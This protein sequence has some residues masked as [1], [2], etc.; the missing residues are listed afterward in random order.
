MVL[1]LIVPKTDCSK[2]CLLQRRGVPY[3][4]GSIVNQPAGRHAAESESNR[5]ASLLDAS[6]GTAARRSR[7]QSTALVAVLVPVLAAMCVQWVLVLGLSRLPLVMLGV[8][9]TFAAVVWVL[10]AAT[11]AAAATGGLICFLVGLGTARLDRPILFSGLLPLAALFVLT[12]FSTRAGRARKA[13]A[14]LAESR[15][16]RAVNQVVANLGVAGL[17]AG[18]FLSILVDRFGPRPGPVGASLWAG[19]I[20]LLAALAEATADTV[21]SEI[22]QAFGGAPVLVTSLRR[23]PAGTDGAVTVL[24]T[25]AGIFA[26]GLVALVGMFG[27]GLGGRVTVIAFAGGVAGL[28]FDTLLGATVERAGYLGNDL[29]NFVSTL[30]AVGVA[31][32][33]FVWCGGS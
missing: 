21:S 16:G 18:G 4:Q 10:R 23:V 9:L 8:S 25:A 30:F 13:R 7:R 31:E 22:G 12:F 6:N 11:P 14:G 1:L 32:V 3:P 24:G 26:A 19:P 27:L 15:S 2:T 28:F 29:V 33:L 20:L 17:V 5:L